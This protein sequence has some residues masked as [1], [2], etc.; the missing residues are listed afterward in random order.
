MMLQSVSPPDIFPVGITEIAYEGKNKCINEPDD[1]K[2]V[3]LLSLNTERLSNLFDKAL[4]DIKTIPAQHI[5]K[6][7]KEQMQGMPSFF[8]AYEKLKSHCEAQGNPIHLIEHL[9]V[10]DKYSHYVAEV[11]Y[12]A[13]GKKID[14]TIPDYEAFLSEIAEKA[15][16]ESTYQI[17]GKENVLA[18]FR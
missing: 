10:M 13:S 6:L 15:I 17:S 8:D 18:L 9:A 1:D 4:R 3:K 11:L 2:F 14:E 5:K 12:I 7:S 16:T